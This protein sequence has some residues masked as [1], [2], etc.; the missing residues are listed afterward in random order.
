MGFP[1]DMTERE[2]QNMC[3]FAPGFEAA[4]LKIPASTAATRERD[5][6]A[7]AAVSALA[8]TLPAPTLPTSGTASLTRQGASTPLP[9]DT[10]ATSYHHGQRGPVAGSDPYQPIEG[11]DRVSSALTAAALTATATT[12]TLANQANKKQI[13]GFARFRSRSDAILARDTLS[14][15]KIDIEKGCVLKAEIAKKD[16]HIKRSPGDPM[17]VRPAES[18]YYPHSS[19]ASSAHGSA[20][21]LDQLAQQ[22]RDWRAQM[23]QDEIERRYQYSKQQEHE[24]HVGIASMGRQGPG[25]A[26]GQT[27]R[28]PD[29][30][31]GHQQYGRPDTD[32]Y[33]P[34]EYPGPK[35]EISSS[36]SGRFGSVN[37]SH[38]SPISNHSLLPTTDKTPV[39]NTSA[40]RN[41]PPSHDLEAST[42]GNHEPALHRPT[43]MEERMSRHVDRQQISGRFAAGPG[44]IGGVAAY[45][46]PSRDNEAA[47]YSLPRQPLAPLSMTTSTGPRGH[48]RIGSLGAQTYIDSDFQRLTMAS[49]QQGS[50]P[51]AGRPA[52]RR[53]Q[54]DVDLFAQHVRPAHSHLSSTDPAALAAAGFTGSPNYGSGGFA[55]PTSPTFAGFGMPRLPPHIR[56]DDNNAPISTVY[57][58]GLP[59]S[60]PN[61]TGAMSAHH[62]E[63]ALRATFSQV[64]GF[65]RLS[66]RQKSQG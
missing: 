50:G 27:G 56:P 53:G 25:K 6:A 33:W 60:L 20:T 11:A 41:Q 63:E 34:T 46:P 59:S 36:G 22:D 31:L 23:A 57:I 19:A 64:Q 29:G 1:E 8:A 32:G 14:G 39:A 55:S 65:K 15:R 2:F 40:S 10:S 5:A 49:A 18:F 45:A 13:I 43:E 4:L 58:G 9:L 16:L 61:L 66:Y 51:P 7:V 38:E 12:A 37:G 62:L 47:P 3:L 28:A 26:V 48:V 52:F 42:A 44:P 30:S 24:R 35:S 21:A 17:G 54:T